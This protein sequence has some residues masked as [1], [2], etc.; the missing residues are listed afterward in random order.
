MTNELRLTLIYDLTFIAPSGEKLA[1][2]IHFIRFP[3]TATA[4]DIGEAMDHANTRPD[5]I[6]TNFRFAKR[7]GSRFD[8]ESKPI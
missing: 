5:A 3:A 1:T 6:A 2:E 8:E 7:D 4:Q